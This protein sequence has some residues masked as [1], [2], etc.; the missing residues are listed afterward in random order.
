MAGNIQTNA[1]F[2]AA[3]NIVPAVAPFVPSNGI[4]TNGAY[5][6]GPL[7]TIAGLA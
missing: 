6:S 3:Y 1:T 7:S 4:W 2:F 5:L